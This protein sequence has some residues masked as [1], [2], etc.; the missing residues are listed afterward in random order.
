MY[1][2]P[3]VGVPGPYPWYPPANH[4]MQH[5]AENLYKEAGKSGKKEN[6]LKDDFR[7]RLANKK[8]SRRFVERWRILRKSNKKLMIF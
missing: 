1:P 5:V 3:A 4:Y 2:P 8:K 6:N 7:R